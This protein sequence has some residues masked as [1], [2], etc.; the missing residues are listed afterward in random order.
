MTWR[1][2]ISE[3][4]YSEFTS[5]D[6]TQTGQ[7]FHKLYFSEYFTAAKS[8]EQA[9]PARDGPDGQPSDLLAAR[10]RHSARAVRRD[11]LSN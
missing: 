9:Q 4:K 10:V 11:R 5:S 6:R 7:I 1:S 3:R 8:Q 2:P